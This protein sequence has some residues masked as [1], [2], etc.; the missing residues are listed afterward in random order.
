MMER[1]ARTMKRLAPLWIL[2][3]AAALVLPL[4]AAA[5]CG[6]GDEGEADGDGAETLEILDASARAGTDPSALYFTVKNSGDEDDALTAVSTDVAGKAELHETVME[7]GSMKMQPVEQIEV[8]ANGEAVL[9]PGGYHVML[10]E[11]EQP[12]EEGE[13]IQAV[14]TFEKAGDIEIEAVVTSYAESGNGTDD[15]M[16][17]GADDGDGG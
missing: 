4:L 16:D 1:T 5:G 10:M 13:T 7:G 11:L 8:P 6:D 9:E 3:L 2:G 15:E 12:L 14:L 17:D